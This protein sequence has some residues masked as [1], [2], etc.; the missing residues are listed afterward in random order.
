[1]SITFREF[2]EIL[3][4]KKNKNKNGPPNAVD[5][6]YQED[7]DGSKTYT[8]K[9]AKPFKKPLSKKEISK[10]LE[11]QGGIGGGAVRSA[12]KK[13]E[14][15]AEKAAKN[16]LKQQEGFSY[17][18]KSFQQELEKKRKQEAEKKE[19]QRQKNADSARNAFRH[20]GGMVSYEKDPKTGKIV[21]GRRTKNGF[22]PDT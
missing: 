10:Q 1:M 6:T 18:S 13:R 4:G 21:R 5:G 22:T 9:P 3:E 11:D 2:V 12:I 19:T 8:L 20:E 16:I 7:P 15:K 14:K 17:G